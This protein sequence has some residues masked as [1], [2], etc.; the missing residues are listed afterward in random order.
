MAGRHLCVVSASLVDAS[1]FRG[2]ASSAKEPVGMITRSRPVS[3]RQRP[4]RRKVSSLDCRH[5]ED[6]TLKAELCVGSM[7]PAT[8]SRCRTWSSNMGGPGRTC[9]NNQVAR[10]SVAPR[11]DR[12]VGRRQT[13]AG[14]L[15]TRFV[16]QAEK[17]HSMIPPVGA[18]LCRRCRQNRAS[19]VGCFSIKPDFM[20]PYCR[21]S[22]MTRARPRTE[23][24]VDRAGLR[25]LDRTT[26]RLSAFRAKGGRL[27]M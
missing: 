26:S 15:F 23:I 25:N 22:P 20:R 14:N 19:S 21:K 8:I 7:T 27:F 4:R 9:N 13:F 17:S 1:G 3:M 16:H 10:S 6:G 18:Q 11:L 2:D 12:G 5:P 24:D